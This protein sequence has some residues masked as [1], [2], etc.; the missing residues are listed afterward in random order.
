[1]RFSVSSGE[2]LNRLQIVGK[3]I[4]AKNAIPVLDNYLFIVAG[5]ELRIVASDA[6]LTVQTAIT[7]GNEG[8]DGRIA[9]PSGKIL[10]LLKQLSEQPVTF[11]INDETFAIEVVTAVGSYSQ[12]GVSAEEYPEA[13]ALSAENT[14]ELRISADTF[15]A[16]LDK[17]AFAAGT[18]ELRPIMNGIFVDIEEER[19]TFVATDSHKLARY[20]R[21]DVKPGFVSSFVLNRK[22]VA[23]LRTMIS[24]A[25]GE[26]SVAFDQESAV[27]STP[28]YR[29]QCRLVA[30]TYPTYRSVIPTGN[31]NHVMLNRD[32]LLSA[33]RRVSIYADSTSL[34][35]FNISS[36]SIEVKAQD[37]DFSYSGNE[38]VPCQY[39]GTD[40][41]I[42][43]KA[44]F[45]VEVL[46]NMSA[47][48]VVIEL[49]DQSR[50][51]LIVP[52]VKS[53]IEDELMLVMPMKI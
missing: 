38:V 35:R 33:I 30:G 50:A 42:G 39:T 23:L 20:T 7:I 37:L 43:F 10:D 25:D 15:L 48:E 34:I 16:G 1:M 3:V 40:M 41:S 49:G 29:M 6:E 13:K 18:D 32:D 46:S 26:I 24:R 14:Q 4:V 31:D 9:V 21:N 45:F 17:A 47:S 28:S 19:I 52:T 44:S 51:G 22:P 36:N 53:D 11:N 12:V 5:S 8:G 27:I 2:L